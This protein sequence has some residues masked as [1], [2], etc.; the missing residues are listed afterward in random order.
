MT[1]NDISPHA[2]THSTCGIVKPGPSTPTPA[3]VPT[4]AQPTPKPARPTPAPAP[5]P[6]KPKPPPADLAVATYLSDY[7]NAKC[8]DGSP[9]YYYLR[10]AQTGSPNATKWVFHLQGGGWCDSDGSC[11]GRG[12]HNR[13]GT[14][15]STVTGYKDVANFSEVGCDN[16]GCGAMM[17]SDPS[18]NEY[19]H[20]W[21]AV[22]MRYC[23]GMSF[24]ANRS[25]PFI[26]ENP[27]FPGQVI[28][29]R[30]LE[31]LHSTFHSLATK[32]GLGE[33]TDVILGGASAGGL[34]TYLHADTVTDLVHAA[35]V[36]A[37]KPAASIIAMPDSGFWP[38]DVNQRFADFFRGW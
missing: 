29:F 25:E 10:K 2:A 9:G 34:A 3:H 33:S 28:W 16:K 7:P 26:P 8:L 15:N 23:D 31:I 17:I 32:E 38:D 22:F 37:N 14:S 35:N 20:S 27:K 4:P 21:N 24:A 6:A 18:I 11:A 36:A 1:S 12:Y 13:L 30:G 5:T 19:T